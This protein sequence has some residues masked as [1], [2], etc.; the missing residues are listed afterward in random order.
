MPLDAD[1]PL[2]LCVAPNGARRTRADHPALPISPDDLASEALACH[3]AG[4]HVIHL[5]VRD[6]HGGHTLDPDRYRAAI[7]AITAAAPDLIIQATTEAVGIYTPQQQEDL[8]LQLAPRAASVALREMA[9]ESREAEAR[10]FYAR[11]ADHGIAIQH[12]LY[13]PQEAQRLVRLVEQGVT[14]DSAPN[15]LFVLG[16]YAVG[17]TSFPAETLPYLD[18]WPSDWPWSLCAFGP[19]EARCMALP[20]A[21]G[22]HVR[23]GFEN[24]LQRPDGSVADGNAEGVA[25]ITAIAAATGR[26]LATRAEAESVYGV[27]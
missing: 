26:R 13:S 17:R 11:A 3:R 20:I 4:A 18:G 9:P 22:G 7:S 14:G 23:V 27:A 10:R 5:H 16:R 8:I 15:A 1:P 25:N 12:I 6:A 21:L 2:V 24:N 19:R